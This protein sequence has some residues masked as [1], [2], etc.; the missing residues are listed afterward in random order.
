MK[1]TEIIAK[2]NEMLDDTKGA[3]GN[4]SIWASGSSGEEHDMHLANKKTLEERVENLELII[5]VLDGEI[6]AED[7]FIGDAIETILV[8]EELAETE[9][10]G[11]FEEL[12]A[13]Y[14]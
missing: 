6:A 11:M 9:F 5:K 7:V 12:K 8:E 10:V 4:E 13:V 14:C 1:K 2:L 3:V